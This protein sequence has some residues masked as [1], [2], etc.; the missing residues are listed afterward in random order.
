MLHMN[1]HQSTG[2]TITLLLQS[3]STTMNSQLNH[4]SRLVPHLPI[5]RI[6]TTNHQLKVI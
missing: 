4:T 2:V 1:Q 3:V 5:S 6:T